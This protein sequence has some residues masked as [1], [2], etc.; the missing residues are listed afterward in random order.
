MGRD[1]ERQ[2]TT[3]DGQMAKKHVRRHS[4]P[5]VRMELQIRTRRCHHTQ[6]KKGKKKNPKQNKNFTK[7]PAPN[8][9]RATGIT[10]HGG[11]AQ[12]GVAAVESSSA[13]SYTVHTLPPY[14][15]AIV[16]SGVHPIDLKIYVNTKSC[17]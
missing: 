4:K 11:A 6:I 7:L 13:F 10:G 3:E 15:P 17:T 14:D 2:L 9:S 1:L 16:L 5:F 8:A 12:G